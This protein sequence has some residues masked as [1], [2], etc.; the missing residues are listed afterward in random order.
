[1]QTITGEKTQVSIDDRGDE[2]VITAATPRSCW[3]YVAL[4]VV[5]MVMAPS[6]GFMVP[7][8]VKILGRGP[9]R[10]PLVSSLTLKLILAGEVLIWLAVTVV[11]AILMIQMLMGSRVITVGRRRLTTQVRPIGRRHSFDLR[12]IRNLRLDT[13]IPEGLERG[14]F[15]RLE[16][17]PLPVTP[18]K[19]DYRG[20]TVSCANILYQP[21]AEKVLAILRE[22]IAQELEG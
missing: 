3:M 16:S 12:G 15:D 20:R 5:V 18:I 10:E 19:F 13:E 17:P 6:V 11:V 9:D 1:M 4:V 2:L 7:F 21:E 8:T 14:D 22:R